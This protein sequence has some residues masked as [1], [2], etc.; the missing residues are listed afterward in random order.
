MKRAAGSARGR[1]RPRSGNGAA[2]AGDDAGDDDMARAMAASL[3]LHNGSSG[4]G[5]PA[6]AQDELARALAASMTDAPQRH[7]EDAE[8]A[9]ALA[10]SSGFHVAIAGE[11]DLGEGAGRSAA[12]GQG[13]A[14]K[15]QDTASMDVVEPPPKPQGVGSPGEVR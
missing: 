13:A 5:S 9:S 7:G 4:M 15:E 2:V 3:E 6:E 12:E 14:L 1:S 8:M 11:E 10:E